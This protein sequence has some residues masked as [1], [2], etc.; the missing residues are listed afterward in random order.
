MTSPLSP[1][2]PLGTSTATT[3][4][5]LAVDPVDRSRRRCPRSAARARRRTAHRPPAV[6]PS[7][8][9]GDSASTGPRHASAAHAA[10]P[11][12]ALRA[13]SSPSRPASPPPADGAPPRSRRRHCCR[14]RTGRRRAAAD[15]GAARRRRQPVPPLPSARFRRRRRRWRRHPPRAIS[16]QVRRTSSSWGVISRTVRSM[17]SEG[18]WGGRPE[19][20]RRHPE[21]QSGALTN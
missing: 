9:P 12:N 2:R 15:G 18:D 19:L 11:F 21:S 4:E 13:P 17:A 1:C 6:G 10:S 7:S 8:R 3:R 20:N 14:G 16:E 5:R